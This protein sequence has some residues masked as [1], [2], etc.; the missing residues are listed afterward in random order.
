MSGYAQNE[1]G[2]GMSHATAPS[3]LSEGVQRQ[4]PKG[5]EHALPESIHPTESTPSSSGG[6]SHAKGGEASMLPEKVQENLP[7]GV[8]SA[9]P[10]AIHDTGDKG[11]S[12]DKH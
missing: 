9:I 12:N 7:E 3:K 11:E 5:L 8:K 1:R 4:M 6:I 2:Q 10:S